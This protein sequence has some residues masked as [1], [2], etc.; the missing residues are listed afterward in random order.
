MQSY[1]LVFEII[2]F[3]FAVAFFIQ[4]RNKIC[5]YFIPFLFITVVVELVGH[6][7]NKSLEESIGKFAMYNVFTAFEFLFYAF[8]FF[9]NYKK[10]V[11]KKIALI[12]IPLYLIAVVINLSFFQGLNKTFHSYT[13]LL[14]S[15]FIVAFCCCYFYESVLPDQIDQQLSKQPFFWI[16]SGLLIFYLGSVIINALFQY[17]VSNDLQSEGK[18]IYNI[19]NRSLNV[20]LYSS[21]CISFYLCRNHRKTS[22]SP[23]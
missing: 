6:W 16:C 21:F 19:I 22:S 13:F 2:A 3:F 5:M 12:F 11:F 20:I 4:N 10:D 15:F 1:S 18:K 9:L 23:S 8:L 14:G 7:W 17:L